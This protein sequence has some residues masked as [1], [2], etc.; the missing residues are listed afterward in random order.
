MGTATLAKHATVS[1]PLTIS[2][3]SDIEPTVTLT[4]TLHFHPYY[5]TYPVTIH[6]PLFPFL[7]L[8]NTLPIHDLLTGT[9]R[10]GP[11]DLCFRSLREIRLLPSRESDFITIGPEGSYVMAIGFRRFEYEVYEEE[12]KYQ[13]MACGIHGLNIGEEYEIG[14]AEGLRVREW[15]V[16]DKWSLVKLRDQ[17]QVKWDRGETALEVVV[18]GKCVRFRVER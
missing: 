8:R 6:R 18:G 15:M 3:S 7:T 14:V 9:Q 11:I 1:I 16:G 12:Y 5:P 10:F 17:E 13:W 4:L 2:F